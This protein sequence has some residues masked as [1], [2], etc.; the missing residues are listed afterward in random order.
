M[1]CGDLKLILEPEMDSYNYKHIHSPLSSGVF[2]DTMNKFNR[3]YGYGTI[4]RHP[5]ALVGSEEIQ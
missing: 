5:S 4:I 3:R 1:I 2:M